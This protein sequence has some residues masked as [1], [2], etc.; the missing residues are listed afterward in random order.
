VAGATVEIRHGALAGLKGKIIRAASG[1]RFVVQIDF[2]QQGAS[3]LLD[4]FC[5]EAVRVG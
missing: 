1:N 5:L 2:I 4:G 3:V